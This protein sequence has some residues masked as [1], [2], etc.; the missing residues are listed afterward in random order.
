M[1]GLV[2][3]GFV[4]LGMY[5]GFF[6]TEGFLVGFVGLGMGLTPKSSNLLG[7]LKLEG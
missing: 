4:G 1:G 5:V 3:F 6:D 2:A 7:P